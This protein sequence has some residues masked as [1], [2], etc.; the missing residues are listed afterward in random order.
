M[1]WRQPDLPPSVV[2]CPRSSEQPTKRGS[3]PSMTIESN[4]PLLLRK[5][6]EWVWM[7]R[8]TPNSSPRL[9]R[10]LASLRAASIC[11]RM[12]PNWR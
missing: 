12:E 4:G 6:P 10:S 9:S 8:R 11:S 1:L 7:Q 2:R 3:V 5:S